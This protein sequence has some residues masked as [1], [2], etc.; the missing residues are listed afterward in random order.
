MSEYAMRLKS[1]VRGRLSTFMLSTVLLS[2]TGSVGHAVELDFERIW[3]SVRTCQ[4]D[5][6]RYRALW[7]RGDAMLIALPSSKAMSGV[8]VTQFYL[9][10]GRNGKLDDY[11]IVFN[12]PFAHV[13][14]TFPEYLTTVVLNGRERNMV[15][16]ARETG[17]PR[18]KSQTLLVCRGGVL[19]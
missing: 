17:D 9:A 5:T 12:A 1:S 2:T 16:L 8:L 7:T 15:P 3:D 11:G 4:I 6:D 19:L 13:S 14:S 18:N 10:P